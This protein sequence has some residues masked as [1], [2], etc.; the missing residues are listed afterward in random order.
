MNNK[1][2]FVLE[3]LSAG[4]IA[5]LVAGIFSLVIAVKNNKRLVELENSKQKFTVKQERYKLLKEAYTELINVLPEEKRLGYIITNLTSQKDFT[6]NTSSTIYK[7]A[8]KNMKIMYSHF[9][10]YG[11]IFSDKEQKE[12]KDLVEVIDSISISII[13][14]SSSWQE[15]DVESIEDA[16][17]EKGYKKILEKIVKVT[18]FEEKYFNMF[19]NNL[20]KLS[21]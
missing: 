1:I 13:N 19:K 2:A 11:Y 9:Q 4:V 17:V 3:L 12:I 14:I 10:K 6:N 5:S 7:I 20:S 15:K 18:E 21:K 8:E 16:A